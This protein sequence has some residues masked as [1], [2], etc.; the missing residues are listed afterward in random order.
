MVPLV[1]RVCSLQLILIQIDD[2]DLSRVWLRIA[3]GIDFIRKSLQLLFCLCELRASGPALRWSTF[4]IWKPIAECYRRFSLCAQYLLRA[5][6]RAVRPLESLWGFVSQEVCFPI[7]L[8]IFPRLRAITL[9]GTS[10]FS[11]SRA[12]RILAS[13]YISCG[14]C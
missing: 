5:L 11:N 10:F 8:C 2:F 14:C 6:S 4:Q 1:L 12:W 7:D 9:P 13:R 3:S